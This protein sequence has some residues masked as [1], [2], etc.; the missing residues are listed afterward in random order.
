MKIDFPELES[1]PP[2]Q[3]Q[4]VLEDATRA[5]E[6]THGRM[7]NRAHYVGCAL[8]A[9]VVLPMAATEKSVIA[10]VFAGAAAYAV[11][12]LIGGSFGV[13]RW[14]AKSK[15][16]S[17]ASSRGEKCFEIEDPTQRDAVR[18]TI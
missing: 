18:V 2:A 11:C 1:L 9:A 15:P 6:A 14:S 16:P 7:S 3:R 8:A 10:T 5:V 4:S 13:D 12:L 17:H